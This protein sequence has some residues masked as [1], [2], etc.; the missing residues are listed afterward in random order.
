MNPGYRVTDP[1]NTAATGS[2]NF[3]KLQANR[4]RDVQDIGREEEPTRLWINLEHGQR[5]RRPSRR[6]EPFPGRIDIKIPRI[7]APDGLALD[8][9]QFSAS[10]LDGEGGDGVMTPVRR[11]DKL[12]ARMDADFGGLVR[13]LPQLLWKSVYGLNLRHCSGLRIVFEDA[14][15]HPHFI[16]HV[17]LRSIGAEFQVPGPSARNGAGE[18]VFFQAR[19]RVIDFIDHDPVDSEV[20][21]KEESVVGTHESGMGMGTLLAGF[22]GAASA[23]FDEG[24]ALS[25]TAIFGNGKGGDRAGTVLRRKKH[26]PGLVEREMGCATV[27]DGPGVDESEGFVRFDGEGGDA[28][29]VDV[30]EGIKPRLLGIQSQK[31]GVSD[32]GRNDGFGEFTGFRIEGRAVDALGTITAGSDPKGEVFCEGGRE[33]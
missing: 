6:D 18:S 19:A 12:P 29:A 30:A 22:V 2:S 25:D 23:V 33:G 14:K 3:S 11:V 16:E 7:G 28:S 17:N 1:S 31:A 15:G 32:F 20:G 13:D 27:A 26:S 21:N 24:A 9:G 5:I 4:S 10:L 8:E